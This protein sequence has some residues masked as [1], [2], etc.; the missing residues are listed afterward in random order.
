MGKGNP[1][2]AV[3][4]VITAPVKAVTSLVKG[5]V[6]GVLDAAAQSATFGTV[7]VK[8][9]SGIVNVEDTLGQITGAT[10]AKEAAEAQAQAQAQA[11]KQ[12]EAAKQAQAQQQAEAKA[13]AISRRR[14]DLSG[15]SKTVYTTAL[16]DTSGSAAAKTKKKTVLG[17]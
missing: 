7:G 11:Q 1:L 14:A 3:T 8:S 13:A 2:K 9:G 15:Q 12:A 5:D 16:G 17:G 10:A 4:N 6:G